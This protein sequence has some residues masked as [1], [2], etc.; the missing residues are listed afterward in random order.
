MGNKTSRNVPVNKKHFI[1]VLKSKKCS[2]RKLGNEYEKIDRTEK[3]I[4]RCLNKGEMPSD[5]LDRIAKHLDIHPDYLSGVYCNKADQIEDAY[6]QSLY[7]SSH[8]LEKYP[9]LLKAK[10]DI[11]YTT[12]FENILTMNDISMELFHTLSPVDRVMFR[13][14]L[15][16]SI[17]RVF[18]KYFTHD[19]LGN[20]LSETLSYC[21]AF[22]ED[23]DPFSFFAEIEGVGL[24]EDELYYCGD[25]NSTSDFEKKMDE[26]YGIFENE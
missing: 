7:R 17:L 13:Q 6:L 5:L 3:T 26:K 15:E 19:S 11:G 25:D 12:Y 16:V 9:Y 18:A 2:I 22:A 8:K 10:K 24:L 23:F 1:E 14:E 20:D 4:R 21:E